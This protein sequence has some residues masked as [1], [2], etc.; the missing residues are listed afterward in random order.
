MRL[1]CSV[2]VAFAA[3]LIADL[4]S[5]QED[6]ST[7]GRVES[8]LYS[9]EESP[10]AALIDG[11]IATHYAHHRLE[12]ADWR[13]WLRE[14]AELTSLAVVQGWPDWSQVIELRLEFADGTTQTLTLETGTRDEQLFPLD[15]TA[16]TAF[17]DV[18]VVSAAPSSDGAGF[19]GFAEMAVQGTPVGGDTTAPTISQVNV[20]LQSESEAVVTW[21]TDELA[22][23]Q[24]RYSTAEVSSTTTTPELTLTT[25]HS[26]TIQAAA[27]LRGQLELRSADADG[28]RAELRHDAFVT[29]DTS[30]QYGVG[31][32]SFHIGGDWVPAPELFAEDDL[33]VGFVQAWVGGSGWTDWLTADSVQQLHA[34]GYTPELIHYYFGDPQLSDV[35]AR[36]DEFIADIETLAGVLAQ[37]GVGEHAL[38]TLEPEYNQNEVA[39]WDGWNDLM[40]E[41]IDILHSQAGCKVGLLPGDWDIDHV[42]P[43]S[44]GRAAAAADFV[45]FQEMRAST[46]NTQAEAYEVVDRAVRFSHYLSRK[47]L[48]PVRLGYVMVSDYDNWTWVQRDVVI[49]LCERHLEL[50]DAG[51]VAVSWMSYLDRP[52]ADGYFQVAEAHKGLKYDTGAPKPAWHVFRECAANGPSW[53]ETGDPPPGAPPPSNYET[54][55]GCSCRQGGRDG[56]GSLHLIMFLAAAGACWARRRRPS[57]DPHG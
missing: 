55:D 52:G 23:T 56:G 54:E 57:I 50:A 13:L 6:V 39:T 4:A 5:A 48:R 15:L 29:I 11:D 38:V 31:G 16:P 42:V 20:E 2:V 10:P 45:A 7:G 46:Q 8:D 18:Y 37:S 53:L 25:D 14:S 40:I 33:Q 30:Y 35:Q 51:V 32:W 21:V 43:I 3:L 28:N 47:F 12:D 41:A 19:G 34:A 27:A 26:V 36:R 1:F 24:L 17:V 9:N 22:T 49:E 44:M